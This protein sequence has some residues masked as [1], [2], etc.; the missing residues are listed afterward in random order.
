M[1]KSD[2]PETRN[3]ASEMHGPLQRM[4][5]KAKALMEEMKQKKRSKKNVEQNPG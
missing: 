2:V 4:S 3:K 5:D 1:S